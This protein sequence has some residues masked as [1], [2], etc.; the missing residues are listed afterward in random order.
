MVC[1]RS[2]IWLEHPPVTGKAAGS[3]PVDR[4]E[5]CYNITMILI[6]IGVVVIL[7]ITILAVVSARED[8]RKI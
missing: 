4:A 2:S 1:G 8:K 6:L 3:S 7:I 5:F